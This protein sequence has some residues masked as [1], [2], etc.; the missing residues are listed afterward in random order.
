MFIRRFV[1]CGAGTAAS[2]LM[3]QRTLSNAERFRLGGAGEDQ[4]LSRSLSGPAAISRVDSSGARRAISPLSWEHTLHRPLSHCGGLDSGERRKK[5]LRAQ[6]EQE[7]EACLMQ[8]G[9]QLNPAPGLLGIERIRKGLLTKERHD[10]FDDVFQD[11]RGREYRH[12]PYPR[13]SEGVGWGV[14]P[15]HAQHT[16][17]L[18]GGG[19]LSYKILERGCGM[20]D[21]TPP[22]PN[23]S[24]QASRGNGMPKGL[25][26]VLRK[27]RQQR[28]EWT[29]MS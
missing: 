2:P 29:M 9:P 15:H 5:L 21:T 6:S 3:L 7:R 20:R 27:D 10:L 19:H 14:A 26:N 23:R 18:P 1:A 28:M 24:Q 4:P 12:M 22:P 11:S 13:M 16:I 17:C 25:Y 8:L